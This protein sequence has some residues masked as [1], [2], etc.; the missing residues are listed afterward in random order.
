MKVLLIQPNYTKSYKYSPKEAITF[1]PL[2]LESIAANILDIA[3]VKIFDLRL[4]NIEKLKNIL[5]NFNPYLVGISCNFS[6]QIYHVNA[7]AKIV[8]ET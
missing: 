2:G 1:P 8:K 5:Y 4:Y 7:I 6:S 3:D